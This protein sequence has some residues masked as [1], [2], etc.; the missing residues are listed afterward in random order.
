MKSFNNLIEEGRE[1]DKVYMVKNTLWIAYGAGSGSAIPIGKKTYFTDKK[2]DANYD[3]MLIN[4]LKKFAKEAKT[5]KVADKGNSILFK[6]P[7]YDLMNSQT[8]YDIWGGETKPDKRYKK[9]FI[10]DTNAKITVVTL[11]DTKIEALHWLRTM[12]D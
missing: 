8:S 11:F 5:S 12:D 3:L 7:V 9:H 6:L 2:G 4:K 10:I 1:H